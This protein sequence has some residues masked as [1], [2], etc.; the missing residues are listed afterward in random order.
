ME[1]YD[2]ASQECQYCYY[3]KGTHKDTKADCDKTGRYKRYDDDCD[4]H[5]CF[6]MFAFLLPPIQ[7]KTFGVCW[8]EDAFHRVEHRP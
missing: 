7:A 6:P 4:C 1:V 3:W 2:M 8:I 5:G